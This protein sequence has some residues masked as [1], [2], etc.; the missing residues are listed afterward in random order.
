MTGLRPK[1]GLSTCWPD[2]LKVASGLARSL[3]Q[4]SGAIRLVRLWDWNRAKRTFLTA[5]GDGRNAP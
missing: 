5:Y 3:W 1:V 4:L 2:L